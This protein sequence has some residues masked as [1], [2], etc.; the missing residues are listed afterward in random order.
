M[1]KGLQSD[2]SQHQAALA[3]ASRIA[4]RNPSTQILTI[5]TT[6][7]ILLLTI[8][9]N[10]SDEGQMHEVPAFWTALGGKGKPAKAASASDAPAP[11]FF[12]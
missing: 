5:S 3:I 9:T 7:K 8:L 1:W 12:S 11:G 2:A 4:H 10:Q 6:P